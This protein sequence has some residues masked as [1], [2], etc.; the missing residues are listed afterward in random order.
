MIMT[1]FSTGKRKVVRLSPVIA[2]RSLG[3][4]C[5]R[6][7]VKILHFEM[8]SGGKFGDYIVLWK[9]RPC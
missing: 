6:R 4:C 9:R 8:L 5:P 1:S 2:K 7:I 3:I